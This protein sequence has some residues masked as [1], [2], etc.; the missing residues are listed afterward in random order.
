MNTLAANA[1]PYKPIFLHKQVEES[2]NCV[3]EASRRAGGFG[4]RINVAFKNG[5]ISGLRGNSDDMQIRWAG[6]LLPKS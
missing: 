1:G 5:Q 4:K 2:P 3:M 6:P